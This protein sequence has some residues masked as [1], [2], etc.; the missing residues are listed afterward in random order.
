MKA[1]KNIIKDVT[2]FA[3]DNMM[4]DVLEVGKHYTIS[5]DFHPTGREEGVATNISLKER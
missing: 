1:N 3:V 4:G 5:F 2:A